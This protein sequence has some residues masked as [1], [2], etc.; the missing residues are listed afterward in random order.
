[1]QPMRQRCTMS[2]SWLGE[3]A[4]MS[5]ELHT[6]LSCDVLALLMLVLVIR[7]VYSGGVQY[8]C[9]ATAALD[10]LESG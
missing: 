3:N 10:M 7:S 5:E 8:A 9:F 2:R 4:P 1:M 6:A